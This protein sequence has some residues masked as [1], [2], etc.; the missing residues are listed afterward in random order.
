MFHLTQLL[1]TLTRFI[2]HKVDGLLFP[3]KTIWLNN[4]VE[5]SGLQL[6][7]T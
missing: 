7:R 3:T 4:F 2:K 6:S 5:F 1:M